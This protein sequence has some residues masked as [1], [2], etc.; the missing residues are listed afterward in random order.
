MIAFFLAATMT[1]PQPKQDAGCLG[2][3]LHVATDNVPIG[4]GI[5]TSVV[6][7][8]G[9][10]PRGSSAADAWLYKN[11][12]GKY[13]VQFAGTVPPQKYR[14]VISAEYLNG[15]KAGSKRFYPIIE[16][17]AS[18]LI[19]L[20]NQLLGIGIERRACFLSDYKM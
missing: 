8:W 13:Y 3:P 12:S 1:L 20:E 5:S 2:S 6:N 15:Y 16:A 18:R 14:T 17:S 7:I 4:S 9:F 10:V 19:T 11:D